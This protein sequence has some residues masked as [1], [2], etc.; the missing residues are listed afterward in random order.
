MSD[1]GNLPWFIPPLPWEAYH[2]N[3]KPFRGG[4]EHA[5][6]GSRWYEIVCLM[7]V[8]LTLHEVLNANLI[9]TPYQADV[10]PEDFNVNVEA[11]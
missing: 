5:S 4:G 11:V 10:H 6:H 8:I 1:G 2:W 3:R 7:V 9:L